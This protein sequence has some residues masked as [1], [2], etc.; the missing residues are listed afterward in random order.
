MEDLVKTNKSLKIEWEKRRK[1]VL[2]MIRD[3]A[4]VKLGAWF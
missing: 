3:Q 1:N 2:E 4:F